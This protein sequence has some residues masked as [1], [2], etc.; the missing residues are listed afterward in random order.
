MYIVSE[1]SHNVLAKYKSWFSPLD[2]NDRK[3]ALA[4]I[5]KFHETCCKNRAVLYRRNSRTIKY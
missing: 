4:N 1:Y 3:I 5:E 2:W